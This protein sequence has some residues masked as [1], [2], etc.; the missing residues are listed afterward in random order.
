VRQELE[1]KET[2]GELM[3]LHQSTP[4]RPYVRVFEGMHGLLRIKQEILSTKNEILLWTNQYSE[5]H[6]FNERLHAVFIQERIRRGI[7]IRVLAV[8]NVEGRALLSADA[9]SLRT[10][11][12]L[13]KGVSF[14]SEIYIFDQSVAT[15]DYT[16]EIIGVISRNESMTTSQRQ[17]FMMVWNSLN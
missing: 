8:D 16:S 4:V 2:M 17:L 5:R 1:L 11:K 14:S 12:L 10:T 15:I 7:P 9:T 13:P 3:A 6:I